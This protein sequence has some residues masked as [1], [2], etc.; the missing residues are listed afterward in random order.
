MVNPKVSVIIPVYN[1]EKYIER[2]LCSI[3]RQTYSNLEILVINDGSSDSSLKICQKMADNDT[4]ICVITKE[5]EGVSV[6]R[7]LGVSLATGD[8][9]AFV[10]SDDYIHKDAIRFFMDISLATDADIAKGSY[11]E[12][13]EDEPFDLKNVSYEDVRY[14]T[15]NKEEAWKHL[16]DDKHMIFGT[17]W[18]GL[19][20]TKILERIVFPVGRTFEDTAIA[21]LLYENSKKTVFVDYPFYYYFVNKKGITHQFT[22]N[23]TMDSIWASEERTEWFLE[24]QGR[25][26]ELYL[27]SMKLHLRHTM[28]CVNRFSDKSITKK[29]IR[30]FDRIIDY[31]LLR[32]TDKS[33]FVECC[34][35]RIKHFFTC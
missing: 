8:Y 12:F 6:A 16:F 21:H 23:N 2:C 1:S 11:I 20:K 7:N 15:I 10:D 29:I 22:I 34:A 24:N 9:L 19:F 14:Q 25:D 18:G 31:T 28:S 35:F 26:N 32:K 27:S 3:V 33:F 17:V 5:N 13:S 4:R 30:S